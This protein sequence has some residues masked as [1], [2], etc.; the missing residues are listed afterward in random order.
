[1]PR[2]LWINLEYLSAEDWVESCHGLPSTQANGLRKFFFF[3]GFTEATGGLLR[4]P[5]LISQRNA[6]QEDPDS[7]IRLL[8]VLGI[9]RTW[10]QRLRNGAA[11]AYVYSYPQAPLPSLMQALA[12]QRRDALVLLPAGIWPQA[13]PSLQ[14]EGWRVEACTHAFVGQHEFD[15]LLWGSDLNI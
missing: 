2:Q 4:E 15:R 9:P 10:L 13:L 11:L 8:D 7:R 14:G 3:P 5:E 1:S 12:A 6:W